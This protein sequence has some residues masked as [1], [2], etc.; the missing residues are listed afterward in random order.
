MWFFGVNFRTVAKCFFEEIGEIRFNSVNS[1]KQ[2]SMNGKFW[3]ILQTT[4]LR[5]KKI[6]EK[7]MIMFVSAIPGTNIM[8]W[9]NRHLYWYQVTKALCLLLIIKKCGCNSLLPIH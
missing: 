9:P 1:R 7:T 4:K 6:K 5:K 8:P 3:Q 2:C